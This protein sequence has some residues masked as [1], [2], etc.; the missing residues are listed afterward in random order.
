MDTIKLTKNICDLPNEMGQDQVE[1][2]WQGLI[3]KRK[4]RYRYT[5]RIKDLYLQINHG[6][7]TISNSLHKFYHGNNYS[8]FTYKE[9]VDAVKKLDEYFDFSILDARVIKYT[10]GIVIEAS[11]EESYEKWINYRGKSPLPMIDKRNNNKYG[12]YFGSGQV[13]LKGYNKTYEA[14]KRLHGEEKLQEEFFRFE[15]EINASYARKN[16][17]SNILTLSDLIKYENYCASLDLL[18]KYY[19]IIK[20]DNLDY[21]KISTDQHRVIGLFTNQIQIKKYKRH[22]YHSFKKDRQKFNGLFKDDSL[23]KKDRVR[24][25]IIDVIETMKTH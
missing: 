1:V 4:D 17:S 3:W 8:M 18:L 7:L 14:N 9:T 5:T 13:K 22:H 2:C 12:C 6:W 16:L 19:D 25:E 23:I 20:K 15:S 21:N 11:P 24:D 10:P